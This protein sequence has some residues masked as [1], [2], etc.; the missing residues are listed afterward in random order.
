MTAMSARNFNRKTLTEWFAGYLLISPYLTMLVIF[1]GAAIAQA[2]YYSFTKYDVLSPPEFVGWRNYARALCLVDPCNDTFLKKALPNTVAY[3]IGVVPV[4]TMLALVL[5]FAVERVRR[6][7]GI[8]RTLFY[9]PSVT[10]S[11]VIS[12]IFI[13]LFNPSG[14]INQALG[15][16]YT[17]IYDTRTALPSIMGVNIWSTTATLMLIFTAALQTIPTA[18]YEAASIDGANQRQIFW[19]VTV[20]NLLPVIFYVVANGIIG[21]F[22]VF[23][24]IYVMT[25]GGPQ[26]ATTTM[27]YLVYKEAF[28]NPEIN[29]GA[30]SAMGVILAAII[31]VVTFITRKLLDRDITE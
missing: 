30:A 2:I 25:N 9:V 3:V 8:F 4:Q 6:G 7:K 11:V 22:Q 14:L 21:C 27:A 18:L 20:P 10:S 29:M 15:T 16:E 17:F 5:A 1:L 13:W 28:R 19:N 31:M 12:I 26:D 24:Q 23:D